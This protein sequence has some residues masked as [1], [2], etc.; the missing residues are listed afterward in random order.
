MTSLQSLREDFPQ[1]ENTKEKGVTGDLVRYLHLMA[2]LH[3][4]ILRLRWPPDLHPSEH[5]LLIFRMAVRERVWSSF[6][7]FVSIWRS[8]TLRAVRT[9]RRSLRSQTFFLWVSL[10]GHVVVVLIVV[11]K[12]RRRS[13]ARRDPGNLRAIAASALRRVLVCLS[14][15]Q[16]FVYVFEV[17]DRK[18]VV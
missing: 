18:S 5:A 8:R 1:P 13:F 2:T 10:D 11:Y 7:R 17:R 4:F 9:R 15:E 6:L 14:L 3:R 16:R 12:R